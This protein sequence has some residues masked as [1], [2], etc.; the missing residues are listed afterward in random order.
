MDEETG[1]R[2]KGCFSFATLERKIMVVDR[3]EWG[4]RVEQLVVEVRHALEAVPTQE[5]TN[6]FLFY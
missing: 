6:K 3:D 1:V 5:V 4:R 2:V